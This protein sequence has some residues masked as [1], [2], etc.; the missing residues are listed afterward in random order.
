MRH[1]Q[2]RFIKNY[3]IQNAISKAFEGLISEKYYP[4]YFI[5][6][7]IDAKN[8]DVNI[9][10]TKTEIK[11]DDEIASIRNSRVATL[12]SIFFASAVS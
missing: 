4:S 12:P 6:L 9:H 10:P 1:L 8:I 5:N 3:Q 2:K 11:F 7:T